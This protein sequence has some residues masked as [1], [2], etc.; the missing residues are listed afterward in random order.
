M[1]A[2]DLRRGSGE[3]HKEIAKRGALIMV[4]TEARGSKDYLQLR[5]KRRRAMTSGGHKSAAQRERALLRCIGPVA[6]FG[7]GRSQRG[8][9]H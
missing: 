6:A 1:P 5:F 8:G 2:R 3:L 7:P 9:G 4:R